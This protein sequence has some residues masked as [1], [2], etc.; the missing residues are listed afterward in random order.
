MIRRE[1]GQF[2]LVGGLT[3][4]I[5]YLVYS[6]LSW[7]QATSI[8]LAKGGTLFAYLANRFWTFGHKS[9]ARGSL[10]RFALLYAVT[11]LTNVTVNELVLGGHF[12]FQGSA[13]IAFVIATGVSATMNFIGMK[14]FV[15]KTAL[16]PKQI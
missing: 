13:P 15:F 5:D 14:L 7:W 11:L 10:L 4:L 16:P 2:L 3:V 8:G 9:H 1:L 6:T 12:D